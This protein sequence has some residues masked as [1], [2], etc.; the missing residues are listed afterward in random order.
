MEKV[1]IFQQERVDN[2]HICGLKL[3]Q[4]E[5]HFRYGIDAV[6]LSWFALNRIKEGSNVADLGSGSGIIPILLAAQKNLKI[7]GL[8]WVPGM[9][10]MASRSVVLNGL[11]ERITILQGDLKSPPAQMEPN[12]YDAVVSNPPYMAE[13]E[14]FQS[15][16]MEKAVARH[17]ILCDIRDVA[18]TAKRLLKT[19][20]RLFLVHRPQRMVDVFSAMRDNGI[21][22]KRLQLVKPTV[23]KPANMM[24]VEGVKMGNPAMT[25]EEDIYVYGDDGQYTDQILDIYQ[26]RKGSCDASDE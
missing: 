20:G 9:V 24:L 6:L 23:G 5:E 11:E 17:E 15:P 1:R 3:I 4:N 14:G 26:K 10:D 19:K 7:H 16:T 21:E 13:N 22:P 18:A 12:T 25:M 2:L 8:E